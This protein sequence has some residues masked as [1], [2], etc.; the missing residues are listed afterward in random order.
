MSRHRVALS[1][2][3][4]DIKERWFKHAALPLLRAVNMMIG[5]TYPYE[6]RD[7]HSSRYIADAEI[8]YDKAMR[9]AQ[10]FAYEQR[11]KLNDEWLPRFDI[12]RVAEP[13]DNKA[14]IEMHRFVV[15][16]CLDRLVENL[17]AYS[18]LFVA[19]QY[20]QPL[21]TTLQQIYETESARLR[22]FL[23]NFRAEYRDGVLPIEQ[24]YD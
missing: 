23:K 22:D 10:N 3:H 4:H 12:T 16:A 6:V 5:D 24:E 18:H 2:H 20:V 19:P 11:N 14:T 8:E 21:Q 7:P 9:R 15:D 17:I 13:S 1:G